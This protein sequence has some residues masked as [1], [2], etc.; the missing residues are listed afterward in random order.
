ML[1]HILRK[2]APLKQQWRFLCIAQSLQKDGI[3]G[4]ALKNGRNIVRRCPQGEQQ[5]A[6]VLCHATFGHH[7]GKAIEPFEALLN[8]RR[9]HDGASVTPAIESPLVNKTGECLAHRG[10]AYVEIRGDVVFRRQRL[11]YREAATIE[12]GAQLLGQLV[13]ERNR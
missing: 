9:R 2:P 5:N 1:P 3:A 12:R 10:S 8:R 4:P 6:R 11:A 13:V 7:A